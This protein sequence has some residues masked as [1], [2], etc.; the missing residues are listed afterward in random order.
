MQVR[1]Q[2]EASDGAGGEGERIGDGLLVPA[3]GL[4]PLN[5]TPDVDARHRGT[6]QVLGHCA[7]RIG[8]FI[9]IA[10]NHLDARQTGANRRLHPAIAD[11][12]H[13]TVFALRHARRLDDAN[14]LDGGN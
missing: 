8:S 9:G 13:Q 10:N 6:D 4:Q 11:D 7:H 3:L 1:Q 14:G 12:D 2:F 5:G